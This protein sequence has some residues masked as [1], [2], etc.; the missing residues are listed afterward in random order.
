MKPRTWHDITVV[1]CSTF[2]TLTEDWSIVS[3]R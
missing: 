2:I 3:S 1:M